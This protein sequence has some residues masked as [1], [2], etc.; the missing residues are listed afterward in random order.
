MNTQ[1][2]NSYGQQLPVVPGRVINKVKRYVS[3]FG[4]V[5]EIR[6]S[7]ITVQDDQGIFRTEEVLEVVPPLAD[8]TMPE[9]PGLIRCCFRCFSL[10]HVNNSY[11]C[12]S[13]GLVVCLPCTGIIGTEGQ[14]VRVCAECAKS[15][16][17]PWLQLAKKFLWG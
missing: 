12:P 1:S 9:D 8:G 7:T 13:C 6:W 17:S 15:I 11:N 3:P 5:V 16:R 10:I 2:Q 14:K 4:Q